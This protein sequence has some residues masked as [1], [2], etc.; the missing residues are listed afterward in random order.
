MY[1]PLEC[2]SLRKVLQDLFKWYGQACSVQ[3]QEKDKQSRGPGSRISLD[4]LRV[5][6]VNGLF[7]LKSVL[8]NPEV[9]SQNAV[10]KID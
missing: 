1:L 2:S 7:W 3:L 9:E 8:G 4:T 5:S 6:Y 10:L